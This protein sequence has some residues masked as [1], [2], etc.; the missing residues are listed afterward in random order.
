VWKAVDMRVKA[1]DNCV[2]ETGVSVYNLTLHAQNLWEKD[3]S[4]LSNIEID[5][6]DLLN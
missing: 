1:V 4:H 5:K 2:D 6:W 3:K